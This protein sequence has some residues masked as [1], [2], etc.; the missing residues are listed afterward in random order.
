MQS[1]V[2]CDM[3]IE[4]AEMV[5]CPWVYFMKSHE[6]SNAVMLCIFQ[7]QPECKSITAADQFTKFFAMVISL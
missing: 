4:A 3:M 7:T 1:Q 5:C 2:K 6:W